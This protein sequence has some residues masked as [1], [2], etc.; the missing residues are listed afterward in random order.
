MKGILYTGSTSELSNAD[1]RQMLIKHGFTMQLE[2]R[3]NFDYSNLYKYCVINTKILGQTTEDEIIEISIVKVFNSKIADTYPTI[4][5]TSKRQNS[6]IQET[7]NISSDL[8]QHIPCIEVVSPKILEF[9]GYGVAIIYN[10]E[11][12]MNFLK[13]NNTLIKLEDILE[14]IRQ[15]MPEI[16]DNEISNIL[17]SMGIEN[18][19]CNSTLGKAYMIAYLYEYSKIMNRQKSQIQ[20]IQ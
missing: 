16:K 17:S 20:E 19:L 6:N 3:L 18:S 4:V 5:R 7:T 15:I 9:I 1:I 12:L 13:C 2:E 14:I 10:D 11:F 8:L